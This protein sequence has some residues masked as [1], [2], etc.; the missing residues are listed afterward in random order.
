MSNILIHNPINLTEEKI[1]RVTIRQGDNSELEMKPPTVDFITGNEGYGQKITTTLLN[2]LSTSP[3]VSSII[4]YKDDVK[5]FEYEINRLLLKYI[6]NDTEFIFVITQVSDIGDDIKI[7]IDNEEIQKI[8]K[9]H[10]DLSYNDANHFDKVNTYQIENIEKEVIQNNSI[11]P[12][13]TGAVGL[14]KNY[15]NGNPFTSYKD[16]VAYKLTY[17]AE[18]GYVLVSVLKAPTTDPDSY[19]LKFDNLS[20]RA[21][22]IDYLLNVIK[23]NLSG[24]DE[25]SYLES[26]DFNVYFY[27][28]EYFILTFPNGVIIKNSNP[29]GELFLASKNVHADELDDPT[30]SYQDEPLFATVERIEANAYFNNLFPTS[31]LIIRYDVTDK[32]YYLDYFESIFNLSNSNYTDFNIK[33]DDKIPP[34]LFRMSRIIKMLNDGGYKPEDIRL[35]SNGFTIKNSNN[36]VLHTLSHY[37]PTVMNFDSNLIIQEITEDSIMVREPQSTLN[38]ISETNNEYIATEVGTVRGF[39]FNNTSIIIEFKDTSI[40]IIPEVT[41]HL[42]RT[43]Q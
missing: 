3:F 12:I 17:S 15:T 26:G 5:S 31:N 6:K 28:D 16:C 33:D 41:Y 29:V 9:D 21:S 25:R 36:I 4:F 38:I 10:S 24:M 11:T 37:F 30:Y 34:L 13:N 1:T 40:K 39:W 23:I 14:Y 18:L 42:T 32:K 8:I 43:V 19:Y 35:F 7:E 22:Y 20:N 27:F 2:P